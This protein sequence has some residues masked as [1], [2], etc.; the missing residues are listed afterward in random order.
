VSSHHSR[1]NHCSD[2]SQASHTHDLIHTFVYQGFCEGVVGTFPA[3]HV[4]FPP[5]TSLPFPQTPSLDPS[6][7][8]LPT[9]HT[10][11]ASP[12]SPI[13]P[14]P[15]PDPPIPLP[16]RT[17]YARPPSTSNKGSN[18]DDELEKKRRRRRGGAGVDIGFLMDYEVPLEAVSIE[19]IREEELNRREA[20]TKKE[21]EPASSTI[22]PMGSG[23][24]SSDGCSSRAGDLR[25]APAEKTSST[26][27]GC[28]SASSFSSHQPETPMLYDELRLVSSPR[29]D[30]FPSCSSSRGEKQPVSP[31]SP[32]SPVPSGRNDPFLPPSVSSASS[33]Y[34]P[35]RNSPSSAT[36]PPVPPRARSSPPPNHQFKHPPPPPSS[37][38]ATSIYS[39]HD[40]LNT[41]LDDDP[42]SSSPS[43]SSTQAAAVEANEDD[44]E[45]EFEEWDIFAD[46]ARASMYAPF[47]G[48]IL[49]HPSLAEGDSSR[50]AQSSLV[51]PPSRPRGLSSTGKKGLS[52]SGQGSLALLPSEFPLPASP[53]PAGETSEIGEGLLSPMGGSRRASGNLLAAEEAVG[54]GVGLLVLKGHPWR[55]DSDAGTFGPR[56]GRRGSDSP[57]SDDVRSRQSSNT[58]RLGDSLRFTSSSQNLPS[59]GRGGQQQQLQPPLQ[60]QSTGDPSNR[61]RTASA[62]TLRPINTITSSVVAGPSS[63]SPLSPSPSSSIGH[64]QTSSSGVSSATNSVPIHFFLGQNEIHNH[65]HLAEQ[66]HQPREHLDRASPTSPIPPYSA[67][68]FSSHPNRTSSSSSLGRSPLLGIGLPSSPLASSFVPGSSPSGSQAELRA[69]AVDGKRSVTSP[70]AATGGASARSRDEFRAS[71]GRVAEQPRSTFSSPADD[72]ERKRLRSKSFG[73]KVGGESRYPV[74]PQPLPPMPSPSSRPREVPTNSPSSLPPSPPRIPGFREHR[75]T[76]ASSLTVK[77]DLRPPPFPST[78]VRPPLPSSDSSIASPRP[79]LSFRTLSSPQASPS[80]AEPYSPASNG[81]SLRSLSSTSSSYLP[82]SPNQATSSSSPL[83]RLTSTS[84]VS[85]TSN[86]SVSATSPQ[87]PPPPSL[88]AAEPTTPKRSFFNIFRS[89]SASVSATSARNAGALPPSPLPPLPNRTPTN[90][91]LTSPTSIPSSLPALPSPACSSSDAPLPR[92][93][94]INTSSLPLAS[95]YCVA[96][97]AAGPASSTGAPS[98][99]SITTSTTSLTS[100][101]SNAFSPPRAAFLDLEPPPRI[102]IPSTPLKNAK[103]SS[104]L[105]ASFANAAHATLRS[106]KSMVRLR[107]QPAAASPFGLPVSSRDYQEESVKEGGLEVCFPLFLP[108]L[109][110]CFTSPADTC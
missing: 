107:K 65:Q 33:T 2:G 88:A 101:S 64:V 13:C 103:S 23:S 27:G 32:L 25:L 94:K 6:D 49:D 71:A 8:Q 91:D 63:T 54:L 79:I 60:I 67:A 15:P 19:E 90:V 1:T 45:A 84:P 62:N 55:R 102:G 35:Y 12:H 110:A 20:S 29:I 56:D 24:K 30:A 74:H 34:L 38:S 46:Y 28:S 47:D 95:P 80:S 98:N 51:P 52:R 87:R 104:S 89:R 70:T 106:P 53:L 81:P 75:P 10:Q 99:A 50:S 3:D 37:V 22:P 93:P 26:D 73:G 76:I 59:P 18:A 69:V 92:T 85:H 83:A 61:Q 109:I 66:Q 5:N 11:P 7:N 21:G 57:T 9:S 48:Q 41:T 4:Q 42:S 100:S 96:S 77:S 31:H 17:S 58:P 78:A 68:G 44:N 14:S 105:K 43:L 39:S 82:I 40:T 36:S 72:P 86:R 108:N 16:V 97:P